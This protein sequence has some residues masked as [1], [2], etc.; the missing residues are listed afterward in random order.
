MKVKIFSELNYIIIKLL[1]DNFVQFS[2]LKENINFD[3][4]DSNDNKKMIKISHLDFF[5]NLPFFKNFILNNKIEI[6]NSF[7]YLL[8]S[9]RL[10]SFGQSQRN[11]DKNEF[12]NSTKNIFKRSL[13][14]FQLKNVLKLIK[15][16]SGAT[17]SVPGAGKTS[18]ILAAY[19][20]FKSINKDLKLLVICPK[21]AVSAWDDE[22]QNCLNN[23][24]DYN[25]KIKGIDGKLYSGQMAFISGGSENVKFILNQNPE[26]SIITFE[27]NLNYSKLIAKFLSRNKVMCAVDESHRIKSFPKINFNGELVGKKTNSVIS[28]SALCKYK[29]IMSGT[30]MPQSQYDLKSQFGFLFPETLFQD[31]YYSKLKSIYVRTTKNDIGLKPFRIKYIDVEMSAEHRELYQKIKNVRR[32]EFE[33]MSDQIT[34]RKLKQCIM[35]LLQIS[36]NPRIID[37]EYF[38]NTVENLGLE[39][40]I[41]SSSNKFNAVCD[42]ANEITSKGEK[43]LIWSSFKKNINLL[44]L[45]L[46]HLNPVK[47]DG[48]VDSGEVGEIGTRKD[49]IYR[50]K[51][52]KTCKVF[53]ANPAA[54]SEGISLHIDSKGNKVCSNAIYLDRNFNSSQFLQSVDRIHRIGAIGVPNIYIFRTKESIDMRVQ[55]R[56]NEKINNMLELLDDNSL[57]PYIKTENF[58]PNPNS[59]DEITKEEAEFYYSYLNE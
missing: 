5:L 28:L 19:S 21:N 27:S 30:P 46:S 20:F 52:D 58:Y 53:I 36:S 35:H 1:D 42:L 25:M 3:F 16:N 44:E 31:S 10:N 6:D 48:S 26:L 23:H 49:N 38:L 59:Q 12:L 32:R 18:E 7:K 13:K 55:E 45:E 57:R 43:V 54:A 34:L 9:L 4:I 56:L 47:I 2:S 50:F 14:D 8:N 41:T 37:D 33:S 51:N 39:K 11:I 29:F 17:F 15:Y 24:Y 40:L 22:I